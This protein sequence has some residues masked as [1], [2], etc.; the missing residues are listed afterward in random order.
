MRGLLIISAAVLA[1]CATSPQQM[2]QE[3]DWNVCRFTMG[4]PHSRVAESER[5]R[6]S[7]DCTPLYP[8]IAAQQANLNAATQN[9]LNATRPPPPMSA[10]RQMH[11]NSVRTSNNTVQTICN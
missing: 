3:T 5:Q 8:A 6:R 10:P 1:G 9:Y 11:C 2:A 4:G 7:L